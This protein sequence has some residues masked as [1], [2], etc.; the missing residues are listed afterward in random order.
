[1]NNIKT[2][3]NIELEADGW[4]KI[5]QHVV[6]SRPP[7]HRTR[8]F[9]KG[10]IDLDWIH[11]AAGVNAT[12]LAL[13]LCYKEGFVGTGKWFHVRPRELNKYGLTRKR[14]NRQILSLE[15]ANLIEVLRKPGRCPSLRSLK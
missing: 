12:E 6:G 8:P 14:R 2:Y 5:D 4:P 1:M 7:Q 9:I 11:R 15:R 10:P 3:K 13:W